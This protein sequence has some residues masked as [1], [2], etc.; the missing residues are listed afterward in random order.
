MHGSSHE[1]LQAE[2]FL[3]VHT[4]C[5]VSCP[6]KQEIKEALL[7]GCSLSLKKNNNNNWQTKTSVFRIL[8][9]QRILVRKCTHYFKTNFSLSRVCI[10]Q[11]EPME[12]RLGCVEKHSKVV[13]ISCMLL[14]LLF[15]LLVPIKFGKS[16]TSKTKNN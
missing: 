6:L 1:T 2:P 12:M 8:S 9:S 13:I 15:F 14:L 3:T 5:S 10:V 4:Y 16:C 7:G 11:F